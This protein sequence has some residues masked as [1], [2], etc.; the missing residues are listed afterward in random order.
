MGRRR[1][2]PEDD[3]VDSSAEED[4]EEEAHLLRTGRGGA[5]HADLLEE[6]EFFNDPESRRKRRRQTKDQTIYGVWADSDSD[7]AESRR[8]LSMKVHHGEVTFVKSQVG[9]EK[10]KRVPSEDSEASAEEEGSERAGLGSPTASADGRSAG[11]GASSAPYGTPTAFASASQRRRLQSSLAVPDPPRTPTPVKV[12]KNF[13]DWQKHTKGFGL[14]MMEK[15]GYK[16]GQGLGTNKEGIVNPIQSKQR[17][18]KMGI[19]YR[20]YKEKS[21]N[22]V[23]EERRKAGQLTPELE[24]D[25][26]AVGPPTGNVRHRRGPRKGGVVY[27]TA[28]E[29]IS[30]A[31]SVQPTLNII[32]MTGSQVS[33]AVNLQLPA[34]VVGKG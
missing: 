2:R 25:N 4:A 14:K 20:N 13:A 15:M 18:T 22:E 28:E 34:I 19:A 11:D 29:V 12:D 31:I 8:E 17:P 10:E 33:A 5:L 7:G 24:E 6:A 21:K 1:R 23:D 32:D 30:E 9:G 3:D 27:K 16:I 26:L